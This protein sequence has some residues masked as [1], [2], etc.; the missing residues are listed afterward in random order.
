[1][2]T[3]LRD[4]EQVFGVSYTAE[5][6]FIIGRFLLEKLRVDRLEVCSALSSDEDM[7]AARRLA[8]FAEERLKKPFA[9]EALIFMNDASVEWIIESHVRTANLLVKGSKEH[10]TKQL[11]MKPKEQ[12][13]LI[14]DVVSKLYDKGLRVNVYLEDVSYGIQEERSFVESLL[15]KLTGLE[16][17]RVM[18]PDT[19]GILAPFQVRELFQPLL[20]EFRKLTFDF[21]AHN[22]YGLATANTLEVARLPFRGVHATVNGMGER[23]GNAA[24]EE[25]VVAIRDFTDRRMNIVE[26][27]L[28]PASAL[29]QKYS[30]KRVAW[31]KPIVGENVFTHVAGVHADGEK[32]GNVY[33]SKLSAKRFG[34]AKAYS[35]GKLSG[36]ASIELALKRLKVEL[37]SQQVKAVLRRVVEMAERKSKITEAD[38]LFLALEVKSEKVE[39]PFKVEHI[40]ILS[41]KSLPSTC[42]ARIVVKGR[43][44]VAYSS[45]DGG[46]DA[47]MKAVGPLLKR[48][49]TFVPKLMDYVVGIPMGGDTDALVETTITWMDKRGELFK[50]VGTNKDQVL[51]AISAAEK[52]VNFV[53]LRP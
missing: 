49:S 36:K 28:V 18:L 10:L 38:L 14:E 19:R 4:G 23:T 44:H 26:K 29:V 8:L 27:Y 9:V 6:K 15:D 31:N 22:D 5:E 13:A 50:T 48:N 35:I 25:V 52:A 16:V 39:L 1:M 33:T 21:H 51:A 7:E 17:N 24:L 11:R 47:F 34:R 40:S 32:K 53:N 20:K 42:I 46:F 30:G 43:E 3:T 2:D 45:G 12:E 37:N 41:Q